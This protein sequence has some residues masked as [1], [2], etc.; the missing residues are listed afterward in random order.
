MLRFVTMP[1]RSRALS[2]LAIGIVCAAA[3][4]RAADKEDPA[5]LLPMPE[6]DADPKVPTLKRSIGHAWAEE[7]SS[8]AEIERYLRAL[9]A[10][11]SDRT[12]LIQYGQTHEKRGL[13][14]LVITSPKNL[15]RLDEIR[16]ANLKLADPRSTTPEQARAILASVP[17]IVWMGYGVHGDEISSGD[18]AL[19]TAYHLLADRRDTTRK[20]LEDVVVIL[21][22]MQNPD[23]RDR[24]VNFHRENRGVTPDPEPLAAERVQRLSGRFNH[25]LFDMNRDWFLQTQLETR[26]RIAAY[27]RWQPHVTIDA[28]EQGSNSEYYF[29]PPADPILELITPKQRE[30]FGKFGTRQ[31]KRFDQYGFA[32][33]SREVYDAFYPGY[34]STWPVLHGS[35]GILWEQAGSLG[36][37]IDREDEKK[38]HY[39]DGVRHHYVSSISTVETAA[40]MGKDLVRDFYEYRASAIALGRDGPVRDYLLLPGATPARAAKLA[41]LLVSNGIEVKRV[42]AAVTVKAKAGIDSTAK[43]ISVPAGSYHVSVAQPA[44][45]LARTLLDVQFDMGEA[46]RK[47]QLD[48]KV[49]RLGDEIYD[50]TSWS[51]PLSFGITSLSVEGPSRIV[52]EVVPAPKASGA[53][54]GPERAKVGYLIHAEDDA[55]MVALGDLLQHG[56]RVH[57]FDQPTALGGVKFA[58]GTLLVKTGENPDTVHAAVRRVASDYGLSVLA[59]D[60]GLVDEGAGLG[61]VHVR[62]VKPPRIAL[63]VERPA[64]PYVGHTWYLFDQVWHF[65]VTRVPGSAIANLDLTKY[66]VV[67]LPDGRYP[68]GLAE[69]FVARLKDWVRSGGTLILVKGAAAWATEK[70]VGLITSKVVKKV[71]KTEPEPEKKA[72]EKGEKPAAP[73]EPKADGE[74]P[75]ESP[76]PVPGAFLRASVYDDHFITFGSPAEIYP[77][78]NTDLIL[79]PLK[80]TD[81]RNLV[82][83]AA[84]D[85]LVSGF[86]WPQTLELMAGKPLVLYQSSGKGHIV[87][88]A[89]DPNYRAMTPVSQRFFL[90]AVFLGPGH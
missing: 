2:L 30:W 63:L 3:A 18:A 7:I 74:K 23:G 11:A 57:V 48:R 40:A 32:Y 1:N 76:D 10:A 89:D 70:S 9:T 46:F 67:I 82:N 29:D 80:P 24:F 84:R 66:N 73:A 81:G 59:T 62:W 43:E 49:R 26:T 37:V 25:Y 64:S 53:V 52:S 51:L 14:L 79:A 6:V 8:H 75:E 31:G 34:G 58:K 50:L 4:A 69:P 35:I 28:H 88:F 61:G 19:V 87:A 16:E 68:G 20:M 21:D 39:H 12:R 86:C 5:W 45:R 65:P 36:L 54:N 60:T 47:R 13:Y 90:N 38:L 15:A 85:L 78:I 33:T 71:V 22:P 77:L 56:Y 83:F 27:L 41:G 72:V 44:G 42:T 17:A 55:A